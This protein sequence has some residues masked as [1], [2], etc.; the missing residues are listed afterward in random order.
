MIQEH[1]GYLQECSRWGLNTWDLRGAELHSCL[2]ETTA[3]PLSPA[4]RWRETESRSETVHTTMATDLTQDAVLSFL[5][6]NGGSVKNSDLLLH[7][8]S[9]IRDHADRD[10][11]RAL[12]KKFVNSVATVRQ[13]EGVSYIVLRKQFRGYV[14]G[15]GG[16]GSS[17]PA[18]VP[19]G[20]VTEPS[21]QST[22][23]IPAVSAEKSRLNPPL[24]GSGAP[25]PPGETA[26]T[27]ILPAAGMMV[28]NNNNVETSVNLKQFNSTAELSGR[29]AAVQV[30]NQLPEVKT[31][32][33]SES[34]VQDER[35]K[36]GQ[37][38]VGF[39][40]LPGI[41]P[42]VPAITHHGE[43][44]QQVLLPQILKGREALLK[45]EGGLHQDPPL[46]H[47]S[48][49]SKVPPRRIRYR[50]SYKSAVSCDEEEEDL[51][52][53][54]SPGGAVWPVSAPLRDTGRAI[55]FSSPR[56]IHCPAP[57][58]VISSS[59]SER[60]PPKI[61]VQDIEGESLVSCGPGWSSE[62]GLELRGQQAG[63]G[64]NHGSAG[65]PLEPTQGLHQNQRAQL[66]SSHSSAFS[67]AS[68][69]GFSSSD[70]PPSGSSRRSGWNSSC[71]DLQAKT[72]TATVWMSR[73]KHKSDDLKKIT[74]NKSS[75]MTKNIC[76]WC[77]FV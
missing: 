36:E 50:P 9:F 70:W 25:A 12:F 35:T 26:R 32:S 34:P 60:K 49:D 6:S 11:N 44:N 30:F 41:T 69:A 38:R 59:S 52:V 24:R 61:F 48:L 64:L 46:H 65:V 57:H 22:N 54:Q 45:S 5:Q 43:N 17:E 51:P 77:V 14:P 19:A 33:L 20:K 23:Q 40:P 68:D 15:G 16:G 72:G 58:S 73:L 66:S 37:Q 31:P 67:S 75:E 55:L 63:T 56:I 62:S 1:P 27:T 42:V 4:G 28:N 47:V 7:F 53:R 74:V 39:G 76:V 3:R 2:T 10:R 21:P 13:D 18:R 29:K 8:K 71:D